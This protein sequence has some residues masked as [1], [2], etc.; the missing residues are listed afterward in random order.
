MINQG[1]YKA[2]KSVA[3]D[4]GHS[5]SSLLNYS[6]GDYILGHIL[7]QARKTGERELKIDLLTND[8]VMGLLIT[9]PVA[10]SITSYR[11]WFRRHVNDR[12]CGISAIHSAWLMV[13]FDLEQSRPYAHD[14]RLLETPYRVQVSIVDDRGK[15]WS[16]EQRGWW[17]PESS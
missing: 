1:R 11:G 7:C 16:S 3:H 12:A 4:I 9:P 13:S 8:S 6:D 2:L 5:F 17:F 15:T 10:E 14:S